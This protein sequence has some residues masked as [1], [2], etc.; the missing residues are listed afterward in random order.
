MSVNCVLFEP[1]DDTDKLDR[2]LRRNRL[3]GKV[4]TLSD[5]QSLNYI[6]LA[7]NNLVGDIPV[8]LLQVAQYDFTGNN[9]NCDQ[10]ST[11]C[12]KDT[13]NASKLQINM[14]VHIDLEHE[15]LFYLKICVLS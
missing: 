7:D 3:S 10:Q 14:S 1:L 2:D 11:P 5:L 6:N 15:S 8:Q 12:V 13:M 4:P 9:F